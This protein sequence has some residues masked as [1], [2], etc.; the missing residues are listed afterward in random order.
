MNAYRG[1]SRR[2]FLYVQATGRRVLRACGTSDRHL[3]R[4]MKRMLAELRE[5]RQWDLLAAVIG[6]QRT[7]GALYDAYATGPAALETLR[8]ELRAVDLEPFVATWLADYRSNGGSP[9]NAPIYEMQVRSL[10][11]APFPSTALTPA[12]VK[13]W[14]RDLDMTSGAKRNRLMALR[15]FVRYLVTE[16]VLATN[17]I[18]D[19]APPKKNAPSLRWES[20]AVDRAV[21][22]AA[23]D[24]RMAALFAFIHATGA[25]VSPV[26]ERTLRKDIDL[27]RGVARIRGTKSAKRD[28]HEAVIEPWALPALAAYLKGMMPHVHP[29][30]GLSRY[31]AAAAHKGAA[32]A[33]G[34]P[35]YTLRQAR[36]SV[37]V[38]AR[39]A[40]RSFEWIAAQLGNSVYQ[41]ATV[42]GRFGL[43]TDERLA[44][45]QATTPQT[46]TSRGT[47]GRHA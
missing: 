41:V 42:Y 29:W 22:A 2:G 23:P 40:G 33:A 18:R 34:V 24:P 20:E 37:A 7:L 4:A 6:G 27:A 8:A 36:H 21:V 14:L 15:S 45:D 43:T 19:V 25:D 12:T 3:V 9:R 39:Q 11:V 47:G 10:V 5:R 44:T 38:R 31:Q 35:G 26:V 28:V 16:G 46:P 30:A 13:A 1:K 32:V 17:P